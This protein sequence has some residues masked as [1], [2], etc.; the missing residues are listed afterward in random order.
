MLMGAAALMI[1]KV[2]LRIFKVT[3]RVVIGYRDYLPPNFGPDVFAGARV[4]FI[5]L[6]CFLLFL[7]LLIFFLILI[8][9]LLLRP[10]GCLAGENEQEG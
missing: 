3:P 10:P 9:I 7:A 1:F 8:L 5:E 2:T 6:I 4:L